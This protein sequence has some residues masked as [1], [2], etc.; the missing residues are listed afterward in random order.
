MSYYNSYGY[1]GWGNGGLYNSNFRTGTIANNP[2]T[3]E[4][5][6]TPPIQVLPWIYWNSADA[7]DN[8]YPIYLAALKTMSPLHSTALNNKIGLVQG[9][10]FICT[11]PAFANV[12]LGPG[13]I[14]DRLDL[15][16][17]W[18]RMVVDYETFGG[19]SLFCRW[20]EAGH[21]TRIEHVD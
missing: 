21:L 2:Y 11:N 5:K 19:V 10:E 7:A 9:E 4:I 13:G 17:L 14:A 15:W 20:A 18:R 3:P 6:R 1:G 12:L 8:L 16:E